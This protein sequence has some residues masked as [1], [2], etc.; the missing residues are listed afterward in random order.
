MTAVSLSGQHKV[1]RA[2]ALGWRRDVHFF[3][4]CCWLKL[5]RRWRREK[6][7]AGR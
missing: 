2:V 6:R 3:G 1:T 5:V 7:R 4:P